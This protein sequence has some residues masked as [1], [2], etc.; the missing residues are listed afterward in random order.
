MNI[1]FKQGPVFHQPAHNPKADDTVK[2]ARSFI[3]YDAI[4]TAKPAHFNLLKEFIALENVPT[5]METMPFKKIVVIGD[6][7]S[8]STGR[9]LA[10]TSGLMPSSSQYYDGRFTN[11]YTWVDFLSSPAY[12]NATVETR[13]E[14]GAVA[15]SYSKFNPVFMF[16][17]SMKKQVS[18]LKFSKDSL[19]FAS[20]GS[21]DYI[22]F[23]KKNVDKVVSHQIKNI[24]KMIEK[25]ARNIIVMGVPDFS[26]TPFAE[27]ETQ[28]SRDKLKNLT[29]SHNKMLSEE[30]NKIDGQDGAKVKFF[31]L[32][33]V[34]AS[35]LVIASCIGYN[36]DEP[37]HQG[38]IGGKDALNIAPHYFFNDSVHPTQEVH[39]IFAIKIQEFIAR[40]FGNNKVNA[41][42]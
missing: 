11:G 22:T 28:E 26:Q 2:S 12:M 38:Y 34:L 36:T 41:S 9:M 37:F 33:E 10:K 16:I 35:S 3:A 15:G 25:G 23:N 20:I 19:V 6:S 18:R 17:S 29:R 30:I 13:A 1:Q 8:D 14:G 40:E 39:A 27:N 7:L 31:D 5:K 21:N 42:R 24:K 4:N 32:N